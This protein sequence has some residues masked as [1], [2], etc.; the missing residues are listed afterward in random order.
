[1]VLPMGSAP[2]T[3][4]FTAEDDPLL[5]RAALACRGCLSEDVEYALEL[6]EWDAQADLRCRD[7]GHRRVVALNPEQAFRLSL[8]PVAAAAAA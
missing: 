1:M 3:L 7:C 2:E 4:I 5:V 6:A 8:E